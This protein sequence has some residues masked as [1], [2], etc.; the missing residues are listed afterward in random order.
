M[1]SLPRTRYSRTCLCKGDQLMMTLV[2]DVDDNEAEIKAKKEYHRKKLFEKS[3]ILVP[4][5]LE[6]PTEE[7]Q[8][9]I[10]RKMKAPTKSWE[11]WDA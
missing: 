9:W 1:E 11:V 6:E 5:Q 7:Q 3:E 8:E 4:A 2:F 10:K